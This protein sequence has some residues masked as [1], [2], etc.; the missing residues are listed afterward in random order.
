MKTYEVTVT[1]FCVVDA[2]DEWSAQVDL[3]D[4]LEGVREKAHILNGVSVDPRSVTVVAFDPG[5][6]GGVDA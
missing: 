5:W 3:M 1:I 4:A 6:A 2:E